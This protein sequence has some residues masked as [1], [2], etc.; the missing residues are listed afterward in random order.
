MITGGSAV[1][2]SPGGTVIVNCLNAHSGAWT[3]GPS[4]QGI[5]E[6]L[7]A[8][9]T[10]GGGSVLIPP[11][12]FNTYGAIHVPSN[13]MLSGS[14]QGAST[15]FIPTGAL[16]QT[17]PWQLTGSGV[18]A[19]QYGIV[20]FDSGVTNA[21]VNSLTI[22]ANGQNQTYFYY[23]DVF[24]YNASH[25]I[26]DRVTVVNHPIQG[27]TG[28]TFMFLG[29]SPLTLN[30]DNIISN[31]R[32]IGIAGC[33]VPNGG[34]AF[35]IEGEANRVI[36]SY[37]T[38]YCDSPYVVSACDH[39]TVANSVADVG[40]GQMSTPTYSVEGAT[41]ATFQNNHCVASGTNGNSQCV[42]I[43]ST[44]GTQSIGISVIGL[45]VTH[46]NI[47][48][49]IGGGNST[50]GGTTAILDTVLSGINAYSLG[51]DC[52][53]LAQ[54]VNKVTITDSSLDSCGASGVNIT[55]TGATGAQVVQNVVIGNVVIDHAAT[56]GIL[57]ASTNSGPP[58][59]GFKL[60]N[61]VVG[62]TAATKVTARAVWFQAGGPV[63]DVVITSNSFPGFPTG[64]AMLFQNTW[65]T[66]ANAIVY[67]NNPLVYTVNTIPLGCNVSFTGNVIPVSDSTVNTW[68]A[69]VTVGGGTYPVWLWCDGTNWTVA[70]K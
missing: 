31:A 50:F 36:A 64:G 35:Y 59:V 62:D 4:A 32:S 8:A 13:T 10:N 69:A 44:S 3:L 61:S 25:T 43:A 68:G 17:G 24:G 22:N 70:A 30:S 49:N 39:C 21:S 12:S 34:G 55:S 29:H 47:A 60:T 51:G 27:G 5:N 53:Q 37:A 23:A 9:K 2:G 48:V 66:P 28:T 7:Q 65:T 54:Y 63:S 38:N 57:A 67:P 33:T 45:T 18:P 6:A 41:Y 19:G 1:S 46:T 56:V 14:G 15:V 26:T 11:G 16:K 20:V 58:V 42:G 40:S 52:I